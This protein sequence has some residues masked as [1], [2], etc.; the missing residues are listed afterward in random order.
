MSECFVLQFLAA[1]LAPL[2]HTSG[3]ESA[4]ISL[5]FLLYVVLLKN[6]RCSRDASR[7][8]I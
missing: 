3:H 4:Y 5:A 2:S 7:V 6:I 8:R 1:L